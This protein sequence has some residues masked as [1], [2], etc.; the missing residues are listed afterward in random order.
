LVEELKLRAEIDKRQK[1]ERI[2]KKRIKFP[3]QLT[4]GKK[5]ERIHITTGWTL[6]E[7]EGRPPYVGSP[8]FFFSFLLVF[9]LHQAACGILVPQP[10]IKPGPSAVRVES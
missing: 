4:K 7:G 5:R 6:R 10:G 2:V 8:F 1:S 3:A 9:S